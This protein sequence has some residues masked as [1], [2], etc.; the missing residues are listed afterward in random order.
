MIEVNHVSMKFNLGIEKGE[1]K[2]NKGWR[3]ALVCANNGTVENCHV[4]EVKMKDN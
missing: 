1:V 2:G 3:A 4:S